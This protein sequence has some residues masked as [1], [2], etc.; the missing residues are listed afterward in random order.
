MLHYVNHVGAYIRL[1]LIYY[2]NTRPVTVQPFREEIDRIIA[3]YLANNATRELNLASTEKRALFIALQKTT[4]PSAFNHTRDVVYD[5][6]CKQLHPNFVRW[7]IRNCNVP[8]QRFCLSLGVS[9]FL[10]GITLSLLITLSHLGRG[11]R[12]F[13]AIPVFLGIAFIHAATK[14]ICAILWVVHHRLLH[15]WEVYRE[16]AQGAHN[17]GDDS[18]SLI[19]GPNSAEDWAW[20]EPYKKRNLIRKILEKEVWIEDAIVRRIQDR[21]WC[22]AMLISLLATSVVMVIFLT[23]PNGS[24]I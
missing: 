17:L 24:V 10:A 20:I 18:F 13:G 5:V 4:H 16:D 11:W 19:G 6:L 3:M 9:L 7:M 2:V 22:Q 14:G 23:V 8:R 15:P 1:L 21:I 12:A